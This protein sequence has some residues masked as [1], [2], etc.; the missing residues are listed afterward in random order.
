MDN[1]NLPPQSVSPQAPGVN[2]PQATPL[3]SKP[4]EPK[5][6]TSPQ[7]SLPGPNQ[8]VDTK[9]NLGPSMPPSPKRKAPGKIFLFLGIFVFIVLAGF[10]AYKLLSGVTKKASPVEITWWGLW[11]EESAY[12]GVIAEYQTQNPNVTIKYVKQSPQDYRERLTNALAKGT[13]PDIFM[14]HN[15]WV[16]MFSSEL[17][18]VP[19]SV[20]SAADIAQDYYPVISTDLTSGTGIVGMPLGYDALTL[21]INENIFANEGMDPPTTW[22][23]LREKA[24]TLTKV[25]N[26]V[27]TQAG[28]ALGRTENVDH[29][30]EIV[31]LMM[32]QNGADLTNPQGKLAEDALLFYTLFSRVDGVWD[33]TLPSSTAA[34]ASGKLAMY[35]GPT[36][37]AFNI[38]EQNPE[39]SFRTVP[40]PQ[41]AKEDPNDPDIG[42]ATYWANGVWGRSEKKD[43]AW[44]FIKFLSSKDSLEKIYKQES[45][46]RGFGEAYPRVDMANILLEHPTLAS[47]IKLAPTAESWYLADRTFD[48]STGINTQLKKYFEDAINAVNEGDE[49]GDATEPL[50]KG[51]KQVL[52]QYGLLK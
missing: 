11:E 38:K 1:I 41:L 14:F 31:A 23:D 39:L 44:K 36:W 30:P 12:S 48:G 10:V 5:I 43:E 27:I 22:D 7:T 26:G 6:S 37:R 4:P 52:T 34:F 35:F 51:V 16:P 45:A 47:V 3:Y 21:F 15:S 50:V 29:W 17:D 28:V 42:Y 40:L 8:T 2:P 19:A 32:L 18:N 9:L 25:E 13:G 33:I 46:Q 49:A 24:K 20:A